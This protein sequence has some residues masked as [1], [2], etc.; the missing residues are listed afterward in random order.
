MTFYTAVGRRQRRENEAPASDGK[1]FC[2]VKHVTRISG[3]LCTCGNPVLALS[4]AQ[5]KGGPRRCTIHQLQLVS[6]G[7]RRGGAPHLQ[8][9]LDEMRQKTHWTAAE[10]QEDRKSKDLRG[11]GNLEPPLVT[12]VVP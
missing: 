12:W 1:L 2:A 4:T 6:R 5:S 9:V 10:N 7:G 11:P 3:G 8:G